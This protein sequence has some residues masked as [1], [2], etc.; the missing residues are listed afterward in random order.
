MVDSQSEFESQRCEESLTCCCEVLMDDQ[1]IAV[2]RGCL[3]PG[4]ANVIGDLDEEKRA[5][6]AGLRS[7]WWNSHLPNCR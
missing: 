3:E 7:P 6:E 4:W 1:W 2:K 5:R